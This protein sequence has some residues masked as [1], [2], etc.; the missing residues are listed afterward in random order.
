MITPAERSLCMQEKEYTLNID[1][2]M[3]LILLKIIKKKNLINE[4]TYNAVLA[5]YHRKLKEV[6]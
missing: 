3:S 1:D 5:A 2:R 6:A 4:P